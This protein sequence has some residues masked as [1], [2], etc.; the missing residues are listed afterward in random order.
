MT[1]G[2][3]ALHSKWVQ[4]VKALKLTPAELAAFAD[5][6]LRFRESDCKQ[7]TDKAVT[8]ATVQ[9][10]A[11]STLLVSSYGLSKRSAAAKLFGAFHP[12]QGLFGAFCFSASP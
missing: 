1:D 6:E 11:D 5:E 4:L 9:S 7:L 8:V 3:A 2:D 10:L 12:T